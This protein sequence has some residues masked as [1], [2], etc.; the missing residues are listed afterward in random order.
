MARSVL[1]WAALAIA[2]V[3]P[4]VAA[5]VSPLLQWRDPIYIV[6]GFAGIAAL[7]LL[8]LQPLLAAGTLPA[9][10]LRQSRSMHKWIGA[11][12]T[13]LVIVHVAGLWL[14]SPPD[15]IDAL[16]FASPTPFSHWGVIAMWTLLATATLAALRRPLRLSPHIWRMCHGV[17]AAIIVLGSVLHAL[18]IEGTM[19][20]F[21]KV[22][23]SILLVL[24]TAKTLKNLRIFRGTPR[25]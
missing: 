20:F 4:I 7:S 23:I 1:I 9:L 12:V 25:R 5:A 11:S 13:A 17:F 10:T 14:T 2:L 3:A 15:V 24:I 22:G 6:A 21:T 19:E 18:L 8:L 16:L